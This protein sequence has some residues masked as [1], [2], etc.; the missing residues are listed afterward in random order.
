MMEHTLEP[1]TI[2][3]YDGS[4]KWITIPQPGVRVDYDDVDP[5]EASANARR[6]IACVNA[7]AG[8]PT[9]ALEGEL[10]KYFLPSP[11]RH[12]DE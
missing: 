4:D 8:I 6:V 3:R 9:E 1:W 12:P 7:C 2:D 11:L 10:L 5:D